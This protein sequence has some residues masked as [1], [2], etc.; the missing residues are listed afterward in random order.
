MN[1][2]VPAESALS[3]LFPALGDPAVRLYLTGQIV[4]VMGSWVLDITL[5]LLTW[6]LTG[7]PSS[8]GL[9]NFLIYAPTVVV[10]PLFSS[11]LTRANARRVTLRVIF[12]TLMVG[13]TLTVLMG[14][15][16]LSMTIIFMV[17]GVRGLLNGMEMPSRQ[18]VMTAATD[19]PVRVA[20]AVAMNTMV[21][22]VARMLGPA[23]A[24]AMFTTIGPT[25]AFGLSTAAFAFMLYCVLRL[26][27][28]ESTEHM[29][30]KVGPSGIRA[31]MKFVRYDR[32]GALF[33]PV[34]ISMAFFVGAYQ[35]LVPV[36]ASRVY[37][38]AAT[39]TGMFFG[40]AGGGALV[41]A[42]VLSSRFIMPAVKHLSV[43]MAWMI[44]AALCLIGATRHAA[45]VMPC[46]FV[47]GFGLTMISTGTNAVMQR[48]APSSLRGGLIGLFLAAYNGLLPL[49]Q[50]LGGALAEWLN[51]RMTFVIMGSGLALTILCF[52]A[53][54]WLS[55]GRLVLDG[56]VI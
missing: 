15:G 19:D 54:R 38:D 46:F 43:L 1:T 2:S 24:A 31:A 50:L 3:R 9:L 26:P 49:S 21:F 33:F 44:A 25:W 5:N 41:A 12:G 36:L 53:P 11:I 52:F 40:A 7:S 47:I 35:T 32:F 30:A 10:T 29:A 39:F 48:N 18:M 4:S 37:G 45:V 13:L 51:V 8:L 56:E 42:I 23:I 22:Q 27:V 20:N 34:T 17:A 55:H 6:H 14:T 16:L 28:V